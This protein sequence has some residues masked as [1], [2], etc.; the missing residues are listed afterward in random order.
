MLTRLKEHL[1]Y[2]LLLATKRKR[3]STVTKAEYRIPHYT[4]TFEVDGLA[5]T[6][7]VPVEASTRPASNSILRGV[8]YEKATHDLLPKLFA[9]RSGDLIHAG[10]FFGDMLPSFAASCPGD[11]WAFEPVLES[12]VLARKCVN[13]NDL[14]SV[15]LFNSGLS[16]RLGGS[17]IMTH[18]EV[19]GE[20]MG[21]G[22]RINRRTGTQI[23]TVPIDSLGLTN[24][25]VLQLDLEGHER[26]AM[27]GARETVARCRPIVMLEDQRMKA[28]DLMT[29][30]GYAHV[31]ELPSQNIWATPEDFDAVAALVSEAAVQVEARRA[32]RAGKVSK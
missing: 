20:H 13:A 23:T 24:L 9:L 1:A 16:D 27:V 6:H 17:G 5:Q 4:S 3:R 18:H 31:G 2:W 21:G 22:S 25:A 19:G 14:Q 12:Y 15:H 7:F 29:E 26:T 10:T 8:Y 28:A 32:Q 30:Y 11:V